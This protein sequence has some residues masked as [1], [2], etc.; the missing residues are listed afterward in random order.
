MNLL[1]PDEVDA[2]DPADAA[3]YAL[4]QRLAPAL[5]HGMVGA[6]HPIELIIESIDRR[7]QKPAPD[8]ANVREN[9]GKIK[10]LSR[11]AVDSCTNVASWL[12][13]EEGVLTMLGE[14][15]DECLALLKTDFGMRGFSVRN[16]AREVGVDVP[17]RALRN[18]LTTAL[19]TATDT[20]AQPSDLVLTA[21]LERGLVVVS[22]RV[23][24]AEEAMAFG[25]AAPYRRLG[26]GDLRALARAESVDLQQQADRVAL[27]FPLPAVPQDR[28]LPR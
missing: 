26:W 22:I 21:E 8:L 3:R 4:L 13:P 24:P 7:L 5:R 28:P 1:P 25:D 14:G 19:I 11:S 9:L 12:A 2:G 6:L 20:A 18:V 15:I 16:E 17:R 10:N 23:C 27:G